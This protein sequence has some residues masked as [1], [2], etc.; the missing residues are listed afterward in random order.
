MHRRNISHFG[1]TTLRSTISYNLLQVAEPK[2]GEVVMDPLCGSGS[3][4]I[5]VR[6]VFFIGSSLSLVGFLFWLF[7]M[8]FSRVLLECRGPTICAV[9][10][11]RNRLS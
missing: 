10:S 1:I 11:K 4:P 8:V 5:E 3:I 2:V 6:R 9:I 7:G